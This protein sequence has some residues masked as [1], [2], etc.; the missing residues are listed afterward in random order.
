MYDLAVYEMRCDGRNAP[1]TG[2]LSRESKWGFGEKRL[3]T[4]VHNGTV[5]CCSSCAS[6][7]VYSRGTIFEEASFLHSFLRMNTVF[8]CIRIM[9]FCFIT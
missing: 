7:R 9:N 2:S 1:G 8:I 5:Q 4:K 3:A 6:A